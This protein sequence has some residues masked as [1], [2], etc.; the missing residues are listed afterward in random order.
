MELKHT[1]GFYALFTLMTLAGGAIAIAFSIIFGQSDLFFNMIF[2]RTDLTSGL[3]LGIAM[4]ATAVLSVFAAV[5]RNHNTGGLVALNWML[6]IDFVIVLVVGTRLWF[7]S[8]RQRAEFFNIYAAL[9]P[10]SRVQ[11]QDMFS[12][13][14]Y[15]MGN[16]STAVIGTGFCANATFADT[17]N[18]TVSSNFCVT[19]ITARTD[20]TLNNTSIYAYMVPVIGLFLASLSVIQQRSEIERFKKIDAKRGG[21]GFV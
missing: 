11:I 16:D 18:A 14:G 4:A 2:S 19:P 20:Y 7:F 13:C 10:A 15:F 5:Q 1:Y 12:C 17:L 3:I 9:P 6:L 21:R 8:L